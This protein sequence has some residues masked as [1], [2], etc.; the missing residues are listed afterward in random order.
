MGGG[1]KAAYTAPSVAGVQR[2]STSPSTHWS[3]ACCCGCCCPC[4][5]S[6]TDVPT[7]PSDAGPTF[8]PDAAL[9]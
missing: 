6:L 7:I 3:D 8:L 9:A 2:S 1:S 4:S 5:G